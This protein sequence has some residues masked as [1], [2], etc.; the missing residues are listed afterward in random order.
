MRERVELPELGDIEIINRKLPTVLPAEYQAYKP[1]DDGLP[2]MAPF[3]SG[4]YY[5]VTGLMHNYQRQPTPANDLTTE[6]LNGFIR[7]LMLP[8]MSCI[9]STSL[10]MP[11]SSLSLTVAR[12][13]LYC[14]R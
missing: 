3:G 1:E 6:L 5:H 9:L 4:Y 10:T 11:K 8:R 12:P 13:A 7:K 14:R 2:P